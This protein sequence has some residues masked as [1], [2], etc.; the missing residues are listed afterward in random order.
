MVAAAIVGAA[1]VGAAGAAY[2]GHEAA[3]ATTSAA[4][5]AAGV[6]EQALAQQA[7]LAA[8]Y[9]GLGQSAMPTYQALLGIGG[10]GSKSIQQ[11]L[12]SLPGYQFTLNQGTQ[13]TEAAAAAAGL[14]RSGNLLQGIDQ[15]TTGLADQNYQ[16][17]LQDMLQPIQI[18]QAAAAGQAANVGSVANNLSNIAVNQ[19]NN[20]AGIETNEI[21]GLTRAVGGGVNNYLTY[22]TMQ[23]LGGGGGGGGGV[24]TY[25]DT[26]AGIMP[27][28]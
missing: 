16:Q 11:T 9:T 26:S 2:A 24:P 17:Y 27:G 3:S 20:I 18:G 22:Q 14:G 21:A 7:A 15:Y 12:Q 10:P 25:A 23:N 19:G 4:N 5:T 8:P 6:Q 13:A 1:V 28:S